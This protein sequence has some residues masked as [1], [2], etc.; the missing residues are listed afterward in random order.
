MRF[1]LFLMILSSYGLCLDRLL[2]NPLEKYKIQSFC[3]NNTLV[4]FKNGKPL[5]KSK[6]NKHKKKFK[7]FKKRYKSAKALCSDFRTNV[8]PPIVYSDC[9]NPI[10][11]SDSGEEIIL[12][13]NTFFSSNYKDIKYLVDAFDMPEVLRKNIGLTDHERALQLQKL[14]EFANV[15]S[16]TLPGRKIKIALNPCNFDF[17]DVIATQDTDSYL[18]ESQRR[19]LAALK[20]KLLIKSDNI[21]I[22][23]ISSETKI[24]YKNPSRLAD[25]SCNECYARVLLVVTRGKRNIKISG[26]HFEGDMTSEDFFN[27]ARHLHE[28][29]ESLGVS[30]GRYAMVMVGYP[31]TNAPT[32]NEVHFQNNRFSKINLR[33]I[34]VQGNASFENNIFEGSLPIPSGVPSGSFQNRLSCF[35]NK[36]QSFC[37]PEVLAL[38]PGHAFGM[39]WHSGIGLYGVGTKPT[40]IVNNQFY[41]LVEGVV[42]KNLAEGSY[43]SENVFDLVADHAIYLMGRQYKSEISRNTFSRILSHVIKMGAHSTRLTAGSE[44]GDLGSF[45]MVFKDNVFSKFRGSAF[46]ISGSFNQILNTIILDD[47]DSSGWFNREWIINGQI[48]RNPAIWISTYGGNT[49]KNICGYFN[50]SE[51]NL[52]RNLQSSIPDIFIQQMDDSPWESCNAVT[53]KCDRSINLNHVDGAGLI[54]FRSRN[55]SAF[56]S[57]LS[58]V[59]GAVLAHEKYPPR[60]GGCARMVLN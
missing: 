7:K 56:S 24:H 11:S 17:S 5:S 25:V 50:H 32:S 43:I 45:K 20:P 36:A 39:N 16:S 21:S 13:P 47:V 19:E 33:A 41:G 46:F 49:N 54:Y 53:L 8:P 29:Y 58:Y 51:G 42:G 6:V 44:D 48:S 18:T 59:G 35:V 57:Q 23:G 22:E 60:C 40:S 4:L 55:S 1:C 12:R 9:E 14:V 31:I 28:N 52:I 38:P 26:I 2:T 27:P 15:L 37:S 30:K 10:E 3:S 34:E